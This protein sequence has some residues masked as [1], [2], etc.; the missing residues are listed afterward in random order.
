MSP[1]KPNIE[2]RADTLSKANLGKLKWC[3]TIAIIGLP[4]LVQILGAMMLYASQYPVLMSAPA[5]G[6]FGAAA[7]IVVL[8]GLYAVTNRVFL[9]FSGAN[10]GLGEWE[11]KTQSDAF[12]FSYRVIAKGILVAFIGIS[13]MGAIQAANLMGWIG[14]NFGRSIYLNIE[15]IAA[16]TVA[17]TYLILL[18]PTLYIA[19]TL[20]PIHE[21]EGDFA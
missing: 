16:M 15:A 19:W 1:T 17:L 10:R 7:L 12:A 8:C 20:T 13:I 11:S 6:L 4:V 21:G 14:F 3:T 2:L 9:R 18:L 5:L